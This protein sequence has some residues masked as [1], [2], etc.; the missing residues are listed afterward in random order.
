M[1]CPSIAI[2]HV[3]RNTKTAII[4]L[5]I[6]S[7]YFQILPRPVQQASKRSWRN[8]GVDRQPTRLPKSLGRWRRVACP[9]C[10]RICS[11]PSDC[12][13]DMNISKHAYVTIHFKSWCKSLVWHGSSLGYRQPILYKDKR[14]IDKSRIPISPTCWYEFKNI[15]LAGKHVSWL[16]Q[17]HTFLSFPEL[18]V[19][20]VFQAGWQW[21]SWICKNS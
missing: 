17:W 2:K 6:H 14:C 15:K 11:G 4:R 19:G 18:R 12:W 9:G 13:Y 16:F 1:L 21:P 7:P 8:G 3:K 10:W 5:S 20:H